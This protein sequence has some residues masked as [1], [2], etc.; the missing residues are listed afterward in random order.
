MSDDLRIGLDCTVEWKV[1]SAERAKARQSFL[2]C[3]D[4][5]DR[6]LGT[7]DSD[8]TTRHLS[9][10]HECQTLFPVLEANLPETVVDTL[11]LDAQDKRYPISIEYACQSLV[12]SLL[13]L[14]LSFCLSLCL[15][16][17]QQI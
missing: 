15:C 13:S 11:F 14:S 10:A 1:S 16:V 3:V 5:I 12:V 4:D 2:Q 9:I 6:E 8:G 17:R 7:I